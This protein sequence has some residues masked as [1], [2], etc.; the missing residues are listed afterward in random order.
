MKAGRRFICPDIEFRP[1]RAGRDVPAPVDS[2][3]EG[4][5]RLSS[6][7][8]CGESLSVVF[9]D[10][11]GVKVHCQAFLNRLDDGARMYAFDDR[12]RF[13]K[14]ALDAATL[15]DRFMQVAGSHLFY[16]TEVGEGDYKGRMVGPFWDFLEGEPMASAA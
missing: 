5:P 4:F 13:L 6:R 12:T 11:G 14:S 9:D 7:R 15:A 10:G 8:S 2:R 3:G 16:L 1:A